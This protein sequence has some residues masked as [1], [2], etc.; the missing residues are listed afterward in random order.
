MTVFIA[1]ASQDKAAA[2][3]LAAKLRQRAF[4]V[5][6]ETGEGALRPLAPSDALIGLI[7]RDFVFS[8]YKLRLE[9]RL[10]DAWA[11]GQLL[12]VKLDH[13]FAPVGLRDLPAIDASFEAQRDFTWNKV[14][15]AVRA[16]RQNP[17]GN[18]VDMY[19]DTRAAPPP[20]MA[21]ASPAPQPPP[22]W[23]QHQTRST[24]G[25]RYDRADAQVAPPRHVDDARRP[26]RG[27]RPLA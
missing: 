6:M 4:L 17:F 1:H 16:L 20:P 5:E 22:Q 9:K 23:T 13:S 10:L 19:S 2:E 15:D 27:N 25:G 24:E 11:D 8:P 7:S 12:Q 26:H 18:A 21:P 3:S 14:A